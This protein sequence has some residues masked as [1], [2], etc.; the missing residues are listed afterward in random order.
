[1]AQKLAKNTEIPQSKEG[2]DIGNGDIKRFN[3]TTGKRLYMPHALRLLTETEWLRVT[4]N[5]RK[6]PDAGYIKLVRNTDPDVL[7]KATGD[8]AAAWSGNPEHKADWN[9]LYAAIGQAAVR[10]QPVPKRGAARYVWD[11]LAPLAFGALVEGREQGSHHLAIRAS[12]APKDWQFAQDLKASLSGQWVIESYKGKMTFIVASVL[13]LDEP[14]AGAMF[15]IC[16]QAGAIAKGNQ[17]MGKTTLVIDIGRKTTDGA[18]IDNDGNIDRLSMRSM[19]YGVQQILEGFWQDVMQRYIKLFRNANEMD[20]SRLEIGLMTGQLPYGAKT[21]DVQKEA[22][23]WREIL[24]QNVSSFIENDMGGSFNYDLVY[25]TGGGGGLVVDKTTIG[26]KTY[27][28]LVEILPY[29]EFLTAMSGEDRKHIR[30]ANVEG[31][32]RYY[33]MKDNYSQRLASQKKVVK[34]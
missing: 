15:H 4:D 14:L 19:D 25:L 8:K 10:H 20:I 27:E 11:Y 3:G 33:A 34:P 24:S 1:M 28:S 9:V 21:L 30:Y 18:V 32:A 13:T 2:L 7:T 26:D 22:A 17:I 23:V 29:S 31:L 5:G 16:S 6:S 12:H